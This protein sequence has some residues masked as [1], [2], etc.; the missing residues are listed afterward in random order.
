MRRTRRH[1]RGATLT[2]CALVLATSCKR[3]PAFADLA[4]ELVYTSLS[5]S[6][7]VATQSGLHVFVDPRTKDSLRLDALLDDYSPQSLA[8]QRAFYTDFQKRLAATNRDR[9][10]AQT[11]ADY[12]LLSNG[13]AFALFN[14]DEERFY[15][16]KP[17]LYSEVLGNALFG[18]ISL[19][20]ADTATRAAHL[21]ARVQQVPA[22]IQAAI[23]NL[24]ASNEIYR[25]VGI[26][27]MTGVGELISGLGATFVHGTPSE[28]TYASAQV[29]ALAAIDAFNGFVRD[30]LPTL[31][32]FDWRMGRAMFDTKW[33]Y[34]LQSEITP[35]GMLKSAE[36]SMGVIRARMLTLA[37]PLHDQWFAG[38]RH[39]AL[40][41][42]A[43]L[44]A[45]VSEVLARIGA[46]HANR[47]SLEETARKDVE[48][49]GAFVRDKRLMSLADFSNVRVIPT[50]LFMR[51]IYG[52]AGAVFAP[53]L[54]PKLSS[55]YW[56]TPIPKDW[57]AARADARLREYNRYKMLGLTIHE[58]LPGHL[59]QGEYA[60]RVTPEWRRL[61]RSVF[62][63]GAYI[64][65][66][67]VYA[68]HVMEQA[69]MNGGDSVKARLTALKGMLR[70]YSNVIIDAKLHTEKMPVD[71]VV[72]FLVRESF[73]EEP[74]ATAKLQRAQLDYVQLNL[75][76]V[77]LH[78]WWSLRRDA[79]KQEG[80][81][82][83]LCRYHDTV[84]SYGPVPVPVVRRLYF[85]HVAPTADMPASRCSV[86][87][88]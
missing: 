70:V 74:E 17:Q 79:E 51:G 78:D 31:G 21:T 85:A 58:A 47:D 14:L 72:P 67:A 20:Y 32:T 10:D 30:S 88:P 9:L 18:N 24:K 12:D 83:N 7:S 28:A 76:P 55:F 77:G 75:Y 44:N 34:Y 61:L 53:A 59:V 33:K 22:F 49:L 71:S 45:V 43:L 35:A 48:T 5:F 66:W 1:L 36:D 40:D 84:L 56:V 82:F 38:H 25:R 4:N 64:E 81:A 57:P 2:V 11:Q 54:E 80:A 23:S 41:T 68:E 6:P 65:G 86:A 8:R 63:S 69:G 87:T 52:V 16:R 15:E 26:E 73:Q 13:V 62:G 37:R 3:E 39:A 60:N 19:E 27:E 50:P 46:D 29:K 42:T